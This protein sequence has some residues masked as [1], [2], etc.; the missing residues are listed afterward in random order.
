MYMYTLHTCQ[1]DSIHSSLHLHHVRPS[2]LHTASSYLPY[3]GQPPP[4]DG[5]CLQP[6]HYLVGPGE[7]QTTN[8]LTCLP[9]SGPHN[10]RFFFTKRAAMSFVFCPPRLTTSQLGRHLHGSWL[11]HCTVYD[12]VTGTLATPAPPTMAASHLTLF[13]TTD[14]LCLLVSTLVATQHCLHS[15]TTSVSTLALQLQN[16]QPQKHFFEKQLQ[17]NGGRK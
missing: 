10:S 16:R 7:G 3:L 1:V 6:L 11:H 12:T 9:F 14:T 4:D 5:C 2:L 15:Q 8:H 17:K 13:S